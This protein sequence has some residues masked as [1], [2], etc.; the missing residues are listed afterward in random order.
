MIFFK[1]YNAH[2]L[3]RLH[4]IRGK[5]SHCHKTSFI[6]RKLIGNVEDKEDRVKL[7]V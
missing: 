7:F 4:K 3:N 1:F 5:K 6:R 2:T